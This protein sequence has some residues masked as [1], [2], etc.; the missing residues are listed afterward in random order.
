LTEEADMDLVAALEKHVDEYSNYYLSMTSYE[1]TRQ[2]LTM[3]A[4]CP[5]WARC[6]QLAASTYPVSL[7]TIKNEKWW[8]VQSEANSSQIGSPYYKGKYRE[9]V[10]TW[11]IFE[12]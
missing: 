6:I 12:V 1:P 2:V 11:Y 5:L 4:I 8:C 10:R 3:H 7:N 9:N